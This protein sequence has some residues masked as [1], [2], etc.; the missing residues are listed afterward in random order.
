MAKT[1]EATLHAQE[2]LLQSIS[3]FHGEQLE[4]QKRRAEENKLAAAND[5]VRLLRKENERLQAELNQAEL[6]ESRELQLLKVR[7]GVEA[8]C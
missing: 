7:S 8:S 2:E 4:E 1:G 3:D 5:E 6:G